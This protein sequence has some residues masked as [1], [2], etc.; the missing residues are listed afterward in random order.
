MSDEQVVTHVLR[1]KADYYRVLMVDRGATPEQIK[2]AYKK[3]A[4]K[5]H[6]DKNTHPKAAEAFK[7]VGA[8]HTTLSDAAKRRIYDRA[9]AEGV[10]RH[11]SGAARRRPQNPYARQANPHDFFEEFFANR[12]GGGGGGA[13]GPTVN[14]NGYEFNAS[15]L[16]FIPIIFFLL[17]ALLM[18]G[19][20]GDSW[21]DPSSA[22]RSSTTGA[23]SLTPDPE[24][25]MNIQRVT[26][27]YG[28]EVK[29]YTNRRWAEVTE[30]RRDLLRTME[31]EVLRRHQDYLGNRCEAETFKHRRLGRKDAPDVCAEYQKFRRRMG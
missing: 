20:T 16:M 12:A 28:L 22:P 5:C 19:M 21:D 18:Q 13:D 8:S 17:I 9:G 14:I 31:L 23:F 6:P 11:E 24:Q 1:Y 2:S 15:V 25:G 3:M 27:L 10:Q 7:V 26:S 29:Y 4:L 30:K